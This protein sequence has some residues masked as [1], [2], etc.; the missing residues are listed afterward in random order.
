MARIL[1]IDDDA[2]IRLLLRI[3]FEFSGYEVLEAGDGH[4]GME[5]YRMGSPDL[6]I[7]DLLMPRKDGLET[8]SE[9]QREAPQVK[10]IAMSGSTQYG[11]SNLLD[12]AK[13]WGAQCAFQKPF[14]LSE[15]CE[16]VR[17]LLQQPSSMS[18]T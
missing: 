9:L 13:Q 3:V 8:I 17:E 14:Q 6:I 11:D 15:M 12:V 18:Y 4:E 5:C 2:T 10:I 16:A 1:I 7:T